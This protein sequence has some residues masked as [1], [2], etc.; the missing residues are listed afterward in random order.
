MAKNKTEEEEKNKKKKKTANVG[1]DIEQLGFLAG[2]NGNGTTT[3]ENYFQCLLELNMLLLDGP[4]SISKYT[5]GRNMDIY[6]PENRL[7]SS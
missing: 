7:E 5:P 1:E 3:L 2:R 4:E 6:L